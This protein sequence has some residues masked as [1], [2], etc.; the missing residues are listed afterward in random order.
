MVVMGEA[1]SCST[2]FN[3]LGVQDFLARGDQQTAG[4]RE[5][6]VNIGPMEGKP[7]QNRLI[8]TLDSPNGMNMRPNLSLERT[9]LLNNWLLHTFNRVVT[10]EPEPGRTNRFARRVVPGLK[11]K[12]VQ[13]LFANNAFCRIK[14]EQPRQEIDRKRTGAGGEGGIRNSGL[15]GKSEYS[16]AQAEP[17]WRRCPQIGFPNSAGLVEPINVTEML[18]LIDCGYANASLLPARED[19]LPKEFHEDTP[20]ID[21]SRLG[22]PKH[23]HR[24]VIH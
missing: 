8:L 14:V 4:C 20:N 11:V 24:K 22:V 15:A 16:R 21:G 13:D 5:G 10:P 3:H 17:T 18:C 23:E 7:E 12:M 2:I 6:M 19:Q 9:N 1:G